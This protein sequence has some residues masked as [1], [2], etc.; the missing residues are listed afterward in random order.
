MTVRI[1]CD[2]GA[3]LRY[4][5][6]EAKLQLHT[7]REYAFGD[8]VLDPRAF[9]MRCASLMGWRFTGGRIGRSVI[10]MMCPKCARAEVAA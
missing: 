6:D 3:S 9:P 4:E 1:A 2:C 5:V 8:H 7:R 10:D